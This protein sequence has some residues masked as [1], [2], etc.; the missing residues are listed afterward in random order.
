[1]RIDSI[2]SLCV[3]LWPFKARK[4]LSLYINRHTHA[5]HQSPFFFKWTAHRTATKRS[6]LNRK[7][8]REREPAHFPDLHMVITHR[9]HY[10]L[11]LCTVCGCCAMAWHGMAWRGVACRNIILTFV[12]FKILYAENVCKSVF[13]QC[14]PF[15]HEMRERAS[16]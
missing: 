10:L 16:C 9:I 12:W 5:I 4:I 6:E 15:T 13:A 3:S 2:L 8:E 1:M 7:I 11:Y 14:S